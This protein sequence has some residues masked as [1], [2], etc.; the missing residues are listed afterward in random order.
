[1]RAIKASLAVIG[2]SAVLAGGAI[3]GAGIADAATTAKPVK[4]CKGGYPPASCKVKLDHDHAHRGEKIG[5]EGDGY[6]GGE[7]AD[8]DVHSTVV[9]VGTYTA[10]AQGVVTGSFTVPTNL[11]YGSH[12]FILTG[13]TS[14]TVETATFTVTPVPAASADPATSGLAFTGTN[15]AELVGSGAA[16]VLAGGALIVVA[17]RRKHANTA[18]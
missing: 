9:R 1:M 17:R 10:N 7:Q 15:V 4:H 14:G 18:A 3:A 16:L 5:F 2:M 11:S 6:Q 12:T 8:G 13:A